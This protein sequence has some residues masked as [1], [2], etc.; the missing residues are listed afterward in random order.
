MRGPTES[1]SPGAK[2]ID[3]I[4]RKVSEKGIHS[5]TDKEKRRLREASE[6]GG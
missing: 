5:L 6:Q 1:S 2:E 4:L 3:R